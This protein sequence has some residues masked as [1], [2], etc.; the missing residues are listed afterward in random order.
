MKPT[1]DSSGSSCA[2]LDSKADESAHSVDDQYEDA[3]KN[4][5]PKSLKFWTIIVATYLSLFLVGL[6]RSI[7]ATA[8][9]KI[10]DEFN[11]IEDIGWYGSAYMLAT[12]CLFPICGRIYRLYSTKW[13][14][15]TFLVIFEAGS[16]ICG[17]APTSI[18]FILGRAIAGLGSAGLFTG[19]MMI[20][21]P[22]VPL[23]KRPVF[24]SL[25]GVSNGISSV[26]GPVLGGTFTDKVTWRWCFYINLPIGAFSILAMLL[27][28]HIPSPKHEKLSAM[29][30]IKNLDP[31]GIFFFVPSSVCLILALQ[32]GG[33]T[34][35]WSAPKIIGLIVAFAILFAIFITVE[36]LMTE[37]AMAPGRVVLNR[38]VAGAMAFMFLISGCLMSIIYYLTIWFQAA[39]GDTAIHSGVSTI[40]MVLAMVIMAIPVAIFTQKIGY[41]VPALL[42]APVFCATGAGL[43]STLT[44]S[45][46]HSHWFGYQVLF[47]FGLGCGFQTSTLVPQTVLKRADV[48]LGMAMVFFMQQLGGSIFLSVS[49]NI[50]ANKLVNLLSGVAGLDAEVIVNTGATDLRRVVP[51]SQ[52]RTVVDAYSYSL[53]RVFVMAT[54]LSVIM[55]LGAL[56]VEWRSIKAKNSSG[57][58]NSKTKEAKLEDSMGEA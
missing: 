9:P 51:A 37:T 11:S 27:L 15:I 41:Y 25:F 26:L 35:P 57:E 46:N 32:W 45:S 53:T 20:I 48:P 47:G 33:T 30:Q 2:A 10:T 38:S 6:D 43:L 40:P 4:Y 19:S 58:G 29:A 34:S 5:Q 28:L 12:A 36:A 24:T 21:L 14:F 55:T 54:T 49:Q 17:V 31:L 23:R 52:L 39:K 1:T 8:I 13:T 50:F 42:L 56:A 3:E 16:A 22:L 18:I 7:I 44:P